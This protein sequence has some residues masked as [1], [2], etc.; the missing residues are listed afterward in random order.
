MASFRVLTASLLLLGSQIAAADG[1]VAPAPGVSP[2]GPPVG[3]APGPYGGGPFGGGPFYGGGPYGGGPTAVVRSMAVA[4]STVAA[5]SAVCR[6]CRAS[7]CRALTAS[8]RCGP[9]VWGAGPQVWLDPTDPKEGMSQAWGRHDERTASHGPC[10]AGLEGPDDRHPLTRS[11]SATSS[12]RTHAVHRTSCATTSVSID[13]GWQSD[14]PNP[15]PAGFFCP[16]TAMARSTPAHPSRLDV[17]QGW[18]VVGP[19]A[20]SPTGSR[21]LAQCDPQCSFDVDDERSPRTVFRSTGGMP[22]A[23]APFRQLG[24]GSPV[25][26]CCSRCWPH[27]VTPVFGMTPGA[28]PWSSVPLK[29]AKLVEIDLPSII[30]SST[31]P[32][33]SEH[34]SAL[35]LYQM[36]SA[37]QVS[38]PPVVPAIA[39][40][41]V[42]LLDQ[43][44]DQP[45]RALHFSAYSTRAPAAP[46]LN[47]FR[48]RS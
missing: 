1:P 39:L 3:Y 22:T 4:P 30:D 45:H 24:A 28:R 46:F 33:A 44:A 47:P 10:A 43:T 35:K 9:R 7:T 38:A 48:S 12:R 2:Y 21:I 31:D 26:F 14:D 34:C 32:Q 17:G 18:H 15:C 29:G 16:A 42:A 37:T 25:S 19:G 13:P 27:L 8:T 23:G 20:S 40:Y 36:A 41:S 11:T 6:S 5:R